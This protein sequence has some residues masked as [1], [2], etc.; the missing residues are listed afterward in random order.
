MSK[1]KLEIVQSGSKVSIHME[2]ADYQKSERYYFSVVY[3]LCFINM[4]QCLTINKE[5]KSKKNN[6]EITVSYETE[7]FSNNYDI[8]DGVIACIEDFAKER[9]DV[10]IADI[11]KEQNDGEE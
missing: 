10:L 3:I 7:F 2:Y 6:D 4:L 11:R 9:A 8:I 5:I 1:I